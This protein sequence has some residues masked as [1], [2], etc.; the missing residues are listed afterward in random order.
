MHWVRDTILVLVA[1]GLLVAVLWPAAETAPSFDAVVDT[2]TSSSGGHMT[3]S[4]ELNP[5]EQIA[6]MMNVPHRLFPM[7]EGGHWRYLVSGTR[8]LIPEPLWNI[9][10]IK[11]PTASS[12]GEVQMGFGETLVSK[13]IWLTDGAVQIEDLPF[14]APRRFWGAEIVDREGTWIPE[15]KYVI[16]DAVWQYKQT[17]N[18]T[19]RTRGKNNQIVEEPAV[20]VQTD[21]AQ[22]KV[23]EKVI[24]PAGVFDSY[25][26]QWTSRMEIITR[27][28]RRK[29]L[30][31]LSIEP[32]KKESTWF[33]PGIGMVRRRVT[34]SSNNKEDI[35]FDLVSFTRPNM[36][37]R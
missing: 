20:G 4:A 23:K 6:P 30:D 33:A 7:V 13:K 27:K 35:I 31:E 2:D 1:V 21:R 22:I 19:Y 8:E 29:V 18:L 15:L 32:Y 37:N 12:A 9:V 16:E 28:K 3:S 10:L 25:H 5:T 17:R 11:A 34:Y 36:Q 24:V 14:S 26:V